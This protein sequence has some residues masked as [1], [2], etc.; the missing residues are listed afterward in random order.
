MKKISFLIVVFFLSS[1]IVLSQQD[2]SSYKFVQFFYTDGSLSSEGYLLNNK[3]DGYWK[4]Y[5][6]NKVLKSE[7]NRVNF[8][9]DGEWKFYDFEGNLSLTIEYKNGKKNG[10]RITYLPDEIIQENFENDVKQ[11]FT[12]H[13]FKEGE[14]KK[15]I[16]FKDG[17]EEGIARDYDKEGNIIVLYTYRRGFLIDRE[18]INRKNSVGNKHGK[19]LYFFDSGI[20]KKEENF[21]NGILHGFVKEF[22]EK[23]NLVSILKY[24]N[25]IIQKEAEETKQY[26]IRYDYYPGGR[27][28]IVG[29]YHNNLPDGVRR[30]YDSEGRLIKSYI[31]SEGNMIAKGIIN[32]K[33]IKQG[34]FTEFYENGQKKSEGEYL[35]SKKVGEWIYYYPD[36]KLEQQ[37]RFDR[38][39]RADGEWN[40]YYNNGNIWRTENFLAGEREGEYLEYDIN[41]R[42]IVKGNFLE[43]EE[44]GIW[45]YEIFEVRETGR[46]VEGQMEGLWRTTDLATG[47]MVYEGR[48]ID[49]TPNGKHTYYWP[50]GIKRLEGN[51]IMGKREGDWNYF[52]EEGRHFLRIRYKDGIEIRYDN[53]IID[54]VI[55]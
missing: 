32:E 55:Y 33:G 54:K 50:N 23:G 48:Y 4:S 53:I 37:G 31:F 27:V 42:V 18:I 1:Y 14:L 8:E 51:F 11:G 12:Y 47:K 17:L 21:R 45:V 29:S 15:E 34:I 2:S 30:E 36:G 13:F 43:N 44:T 24:E 3:P 35:N 19:W 39:G 28:K 7:G 9:L 20:A 46:Y 41:G 22:D 16:F 49:G 10:K 6:E 25:G 52:T 5:Y 26:E 40:W 38:S